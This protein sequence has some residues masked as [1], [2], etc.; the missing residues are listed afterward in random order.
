[1]KEKNGKLTPLSNLFFYAGLVSDEH[2]IGGMIPEMNEDESEMLLSY[3]P[4]RSELDKIKTLLSSCF[5]SYPSPPFLVSFHL[6]PV[7]CPRAIN[8][9]SFEP[10]TTSTGGER[11]SSNCAS[12][13][14]VGQQKLHCLLRIDKGA[15]R[16]PTATGQPQDRDSA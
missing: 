12:M 14:E 11:R 15:L 13:L 5:L 8:P 4:V 9:P 16:R 7:Q 10:T 6:L 2:Q 3:F 1:M